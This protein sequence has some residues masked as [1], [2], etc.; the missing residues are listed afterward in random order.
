MQGQINYSTVTLTTEICCNCGMPFAMPSTLQQKYE[1]DG[2]TFY[3]PKGHPQHYTTTKAQKHQQQIERMQREHALQLNTVKTE[4]EDKKREV[5]NL[6][7]KKTKLEKRIAAGVC[8][9]CNRT[10]QDLANHMKTKHPKY[11]KNS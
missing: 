8:P 6:K 2:G 4:L 3:C 1:E 7:T 11:K 10:F 9:C 5:I